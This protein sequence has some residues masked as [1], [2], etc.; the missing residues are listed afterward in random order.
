MTLKS[1]FKI[2]NPGMFVF[3][4]FYAIVGAV[5][6]YVLVLS[7]FNLYHV[8]VLGFL[9]LITAYGL[10]RMKPW[11]VLLVVVLLC[12]G[13]TFGAITLYSSFMIP[14]FYA[15]PEAWLLQA[16]LILYLLFTVAAST[17]VVAKRKSFSKTET[18]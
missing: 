17:Y 3:S 6:I 1:K 16:L 13:I 12:L 7:S 10:I 9:S 18:E 11:S 4:V 14:T 2:E 5:L 8:G 15:N